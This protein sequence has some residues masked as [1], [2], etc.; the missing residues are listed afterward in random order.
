[1]KRTLST[2]TLAAV[3][4]LGTS[5]SA[6]QTLRYSV[7]TAGALAVTG[8]TLGLSGGAGPNSPGTN[9]SIAAFTTLDLRSVDGDFPS[10]TTS[11]WRSNES[12]AFLDIPGDSVVLYAELLW[13]GSWAAG[14]ENVRANLD[15]SVSLTTPEGANSIPPDPTTAREL[16]LTADS[17]FDV[18]YYTRS[19]NV[20]EEVRDAGR[21]FYTSE[22]CP[23]PRIRSCKS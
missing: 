15:D 3:L 12:S 18:R 9:G 10:G 7:T 21:G 1:M 5:A 19:A 11:N 2:V 13:G 22:A 17:G 20:T 6:E 14:A 4:L 16:D 23:G 8:N